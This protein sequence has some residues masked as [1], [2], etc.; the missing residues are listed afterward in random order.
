MKANGLFSQSGRP[1]RLTV[2]FGLNEIIYLQKI[3]IKTQKFNVFKFCA[4]SKLLE[5]VKKHQSQKFDNNG[6]HEMEY[7]ASSDS[8]W[9]NSEFCISFGMVQCTAYCELVRDFSVWVIEGLDGTGAWI[10]VLDND[11]F[12]LFVLSMR[13]L[14]FQV[15]KESFLDLIKYIIWNKLHRIISFN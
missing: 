1:F 13:Q 6:C 2:H 14:V 7:L 15:S 11:L 10:P 8:P 12:G 5:P 9:E 3:F 4:I